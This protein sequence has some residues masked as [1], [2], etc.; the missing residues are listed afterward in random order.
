MQLDSE[1]QVTNEEPPTSPEDN[2]FQGHADEEKVC[3]LRFILS[4][5]KF[6]LLT[7]VYPQEEE[8]NT[9]HDQTDDVGFDPAP[10]E[11]ADSPSTPVTHPNPDEVETPAIRNKH[12]V[13][14]VPRSR[15]SNS[16]LNPSS[17]FEDIQDKEETASK[18]RRTGAPAPRRWYC[19]HVE[20]KI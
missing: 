4:L 13:A 7:T 15:L 16:S 18:K 12:A 2:D 11:P 8:E 9:G 5:F 3:N 19:G 10:D 20:E 17:H 14:K 6:H 1:F